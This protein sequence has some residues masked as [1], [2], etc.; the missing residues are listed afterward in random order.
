MR[1]VR[2]HNITDVTRLAPHAVTVGLVRIG[3]G[4]CA[5][6]PSA[7]IT[8][9][10][11]ALH[12]ELIWLGIL[13]ASLV[14]KRK[15]KKVVV[16]KPMTQQEIETHVQNMTL[17]ALTSLLEKYEVQCRGMPYEMLH[18][19]VMELV[20]D[21]F[22]LDPNDVYWLRRWKRLPNGDFKEIE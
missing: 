17:H 5:H 1:N 11:R 18:S 19:H 20:K 13:P 22:S 9:K 7:S 15:A 2:V 21:P 14:K 3:A 8:G 4:K 12:G 10:V 16:S 6:I